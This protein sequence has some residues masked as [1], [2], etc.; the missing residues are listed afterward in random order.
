MH[1]IV[2]RNL[3]TSSSPW[4][5]IIFCVMWA[6]L[7][8]PWK[9]SNVKSTRIITH[10]DTY[11][12]YAQ[13]KVHVYYCVEEW[14]QRIFWLLKRFAVY[15]LNRF[16]L[17]DIKERIFHCC[18]TSRRQ[19]IFTSYELFFR[20]FIHSSGVTSIKNFFKSKN[21]ISFIPILHFIYMY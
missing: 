20:F 14:Y 17:L 3:T 11:K 16:Y 9:G 10:T 8:L 4:H 21:L 18:S 6:D 2:N 19:T 13:F 5:H 7:L 12:L 1:L 15:F